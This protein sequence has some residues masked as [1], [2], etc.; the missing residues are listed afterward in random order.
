MSLVSQLQTRYEWTPNYR[1]VYKKPVPQGLNTFRVPQTTGQPGWIVLTYEKTIPICVW[2]STT[3]E[4]SK[5]PC[6]AD[7]RICGDT[8]I[9]VERIGKLD[10]VVADIWMYNSNCVF[11]CT[12]FKQRYDWSEKLL[13]KFVSCVEGLTIDLIHKSDLGDLDL[14]G[15]EEHTNE[16]AG[17]PG[18]FIEKDD[19]EVLDI[20]KLSS[21]DCYEVV[22]KGYLRVPDI[23][24]SVYLRLKGDSFKCKCVKYDEEYW[25]IKENIPDLEVNAS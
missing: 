22:G 6:I 7:E 17:K 24:T 11:A 25:D 15:H 18:Y 13:K 14:K 8:F 16:V 12:T 1:L 19:S 3:G 10:F 5:L 9:K 20:I 2:I 21:P 23:K 4:C